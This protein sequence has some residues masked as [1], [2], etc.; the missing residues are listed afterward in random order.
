MRKL[1]SVLAFVVVLAVGYSPARACTTDADCDNG[2]VCDGV[3]H[4]Q[5]GVCYNGKPLFCDDA[6]PCTTNTCDATL[7]CQFPAAAGCMVGSTRLKLGDRHDLRFLLQTDGSLAGGAFP[8]ANGP[9]DP[10]LHGASV[11]IYTTHGDT[12]DNTYGLPTSNW[13]YVGTGGHFVYVYKDLQ[14]LL[15]PIALMVVRNGQP[16]KIKG[17]GTALNF[18]LGSDP[19]PVH[20]VLR[21]GDMIDC[22]ESG[23][24]Q[25]RFVAGTI[26][27][28][29]HSPPPATCP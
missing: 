19:Q 29:L 6:D 10:T 4:C 12:F 8:Q 15:G 28:A 17:S 3:E 20:V 1:S 9:N 24:G 21:F 27:Q 2:N 26:F 14:R 18:S 16:T 5:A 25:R 11:R 7:G 22:L 13:S 23:G